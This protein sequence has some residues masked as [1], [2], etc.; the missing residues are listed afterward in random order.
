MKNQRIFNKAYL[1]LTFSTTLILGQSYVDHFDNLDNWT[2]TTN[3]SFNNEEWYIDI[4]G[5]DGNGA[6]SDVGGYGYG[7]QLT[8]SFTFNSEATIKLWV[9]KQAGDGVRI[10]LY[11]DDVE[12][13]VFGNVGDPGSTWVQNQAIENSGSHAIII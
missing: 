12:M 13:W 5:Y 4:N 2:N 6:R 3:S 8:Q 1:I 9:K 10:Y 11:V 7:D